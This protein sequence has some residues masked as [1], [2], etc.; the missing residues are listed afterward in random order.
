ME[1]MV[2][3]GRNKNL[4]NLEFEFPAQNPSN[5]CGKHTALDSQVDASSQNKNLFENNGRSATRYGQWPRQLS[6]VY[7]YTHYYSNNGNAS[8]YQEYICQFRNKDYL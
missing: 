6:V 5:T 7:N 3:P 8:P 2:A 1:I 4:C